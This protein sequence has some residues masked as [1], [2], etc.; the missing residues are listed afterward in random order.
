MLLFCSLQIQAQQ[1]KYFVTPVGDD[2]N[3]RT[4]DD[5]A[6]TIPITVLDYET[7]DSIDL[8][9]RLKSSELQAQNT[10]GAAASQLIIVEKES[11]DILDLLF[12]HLG[13]TQSDYTDWI[14]ERQHLRLDGEW[15]YRIVGLGTQPIVIDSLI[16]NEAP[17]G[18]PGTAFGNLNWLGDKRMRMFIIAINETVF[19]NSRGER[20]WIGKDENDRLHIM[21][22]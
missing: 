8:E 13:V 1:F 16:V 14:N 9:T 10:I 7:I 17:N 15:I 3:Y 18:I 4:E 12:L 22:R 2:F 11:E 6:N 21:E 19:L 5:R 20:F